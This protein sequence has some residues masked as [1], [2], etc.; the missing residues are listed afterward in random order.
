M[1]YSSHTNTRIAAD[2]LCV[3]PD[4]SGLEL[5]GYSYF[6]YKGT[7]CQLRV[8]GDTEP[9]C[10]EKLLNEYSEDLLELLADHWHDPQRQA[11]DFIALSAFSAGVLFL[12]ELLPAQ[13]LR[14]ATY[15]MNG[16]LRI[17]V[18]FAGDKTRDRPV[19][20]ESVVIRSPKFSGRMRGIML[21]ENSGNEIFAPDD[22][23]D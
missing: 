21:C 9:F 7:A 14:C 3:R 12:A 10:L 18:V 23:V 1:D 2:V 5:F 4:N 16:S 13:A 6:H 19:F 11:N 17:R 15:T 20:S 8:A 22:D